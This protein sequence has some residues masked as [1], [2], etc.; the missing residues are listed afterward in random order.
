IKGLKIGAFLRRHKKAEEELA[1]G[2]GISVGRSAVLRLFAAGV[3]AAAVAVPT[4]I[5]LSNNNGPGAASAISAPGVKA[6][7]AKGTEGVAFRDPDYPVFRAAAARAHKPFG[8]YLFLHP[9]EGGAAQADYFLAWARPKPGDLQ[10]VVDSE[11]G[12]PEGA[13]AQTLNALNELKARGYRPILYASS[14]YVAGLVAARPAIKAFRVWYAEYGPTLHRVAG[15]TAVAWQYTD[16][17]G[18]KGLRVDGSRLLV[19]VAALTIPKPASQQVQHP[20]PRPGPKPAQK[21][22]K[23]AA[24]RT[25]ASLRT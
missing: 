24:K 2:V 22:V 23:A 9:D 17:A 21:P 8:G 10:P 1:I 20:A 18:V 7:E 5:D 13:A 11:T 19:G 14:S 25:A 4:M 16:A 15:T 3:A 6:V 12:S